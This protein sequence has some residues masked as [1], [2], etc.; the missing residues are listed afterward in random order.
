MPQGYFEAF[1]EST[2]IDWKDIYPLTKYHSFQNKILNNVLYLHKIIFKLGKVK[3]PGCSF[4]SLPEKQLFI[5]LMFMC[6]IYM[7]PSLVPFFR[8][9][10]YP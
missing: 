10:H 5:Y 6:T 1:F 4:L 3:S 7:E 9:Y 8:L 2:T